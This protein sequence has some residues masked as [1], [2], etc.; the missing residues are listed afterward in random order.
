[1]TRRYAPPVRVPRPLL[2]AAAG[3]VAIAVAVPASAHRGEPV[4]AEAAKHKH[5][6]WSTEELPVKIPAGDKRSLYVRIKNTSSPSHKQ[7]LTLTEGTDGGPPDYHHDWFKGDE[8]ISHDVQT[9][10]YHFA[11]KHGKT[12]RFRIRVKVTD[13]SNPECLLASFHV[14]PEAS[15]VSPGF[16]VNGHGFCAI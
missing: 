11:L 10:G 16:N 1:M 8:D 12:K 7:H 2:V 6:P 3:L 14:E 13:D 15:D 4:L 9:S 5:G